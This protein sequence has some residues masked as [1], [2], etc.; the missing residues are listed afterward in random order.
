ML[1]SL[2]RFLANVSS[3]SRP[4]ADSKICSPI[5]HRTV[6]IA[7]VWYSA[8]A[9]SRAFCSEWPPARKSCVSRSIELTADACFQILAARPCRVAFRLARAF[10]PALR[11]PWP[12]SAFALLAVICFSDAHRPY[13]AASLNSPSIISCDAC[14][15]RRAR[16]WSRR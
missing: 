10:P 5:R 2:R 4:S 13:S 16:N 12:L 6:R 8:T 11:G 1:W 7:L 9:A 3:E 14:S 15:S